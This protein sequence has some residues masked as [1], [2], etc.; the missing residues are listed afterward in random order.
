MNISVPFQLLLGNYYR[1]DVVNSP[2]LSCILDQ[3]KENQSSLPRKVR[4]Y[5]FMQF[6]NS[7]EFKIGVVG[8]WKTADP[9][10]PP[11]PRVSL[12]VAT[13]SKRPRRCARWLVPQ[14]TAAGPGW[15]RACYAAMRCTWALVSRHLNLNLKL[16]LE[17]LRHG[18]IRFVSP[19]YFLF[20]SCSFASISPESQCVCLKFTN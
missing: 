2:F 1:F 4:W 6:E 19:A 9:P 10:P 12:A 3:C 20:S 7:E 5:I 18:P 11:P 8:K 17:A 15:R 13:L 16:W 14:P